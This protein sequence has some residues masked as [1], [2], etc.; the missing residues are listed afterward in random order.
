MREESIGVLPRYYRDNDP[1]GNSLLMSFGSAWVNGAR[2]HG[3]CA[4]RRHAVLQPCLGATHTTP[5]GDR[6]GRARGSRVA[7]GEAAGGQ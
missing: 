2:A 7:G 1:A 4:D 5:C 6:L 3:A